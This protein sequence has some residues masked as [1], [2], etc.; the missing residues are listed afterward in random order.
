MTGHPSSSVL[1]ATESLLEQVTFNLIA[2]LLTPV[3]SEV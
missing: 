1:P 3:K 2:V